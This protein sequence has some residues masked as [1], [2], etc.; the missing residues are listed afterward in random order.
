MQEQPHLPGEWKHPL[1]CLSRTWLDTWSK[2]WQLLREQVV[3]WGWLRLLDEQKDSW[4]NQEGR[5]LGI[6]GKRALF[7]SYC[8]SGLEMGSLHLLCGGSQHSPDVNGAPHLTLT[9]HTEGRTMERKSWMLK[10][11]DGCFALPELYPCMGINSF[12]SGRR[13]GGCWWAFLYNL[14]P[15]SCWAIWKERGLSMLRQEGQLA[16]ARG[17]SAESARTDFLRTSGVARSRHKN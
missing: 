17:L 5:F 6:T 7:L 11:L 15:A 10:S 16:S 8:L 4:R 2:Q 1:T 12:L 13:L 14:L 9:S 3:G